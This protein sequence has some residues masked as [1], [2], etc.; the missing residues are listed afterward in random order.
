MTVVSVQNGER[1]DPSAAASASVDSVATSFLPTLKHAF[2]T[3]VSCDILDTIVQA[4]AQ[5][6]KLQ[7]HLQP[8]NEE[9]DPNDDN[10]QNNIKSS[11]VN[12]FWKQVRASDYVS[13]KNDWSDLRRTLLY[14]RTETRFYQEVLPRLQ[15]K[16]ASLVQHLTPTV[17]HA[18]YTLEPWI[19]EDERATALACPQIDKDTLPDPKS[20]GGCLIL[21]CMDATKYYQDSPLTIEECQHCL[22]AVA[23]LHAAA[24]QD[25]DLL[26]FAEERLSKAS[27]H[28]RMR[29]PKELAGI[30]RTWQDFVQAFELPLQDCGLWQVTSFQQMGQRMARLAEY[31]SDQVSPQ[32]TDR[33]A[34]LIHGDYKS[35]NVFL[36]QKQQCAVSNYDDLPTNDI[37]DDHAVLVDFAST[38]VGL[39]MSDL[40]MHIRHAVLPEHLQNG[41]EEALVR[42]YWEYLCTHI[43]GETQYPWEDAWRHYRLAVVDYFRFFLARMWKGATPATLAKK[44]DNKNVNLINR[45]IP[46]AIAFLQKV[47]EYLAEV[48]K[49]YEASH[50]NDGL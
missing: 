48:E 4:N 22:H 31:V 41:G 12:V 30:E 35:M 28:L 32:P 26:T 25:V 11:V 42:Y 34:T 15:A 27:F 46:A 21:E 17:Y 24:W 3:A 7:V 5:G 40:A 37:A 2:P 1:V 18:E 14:A 19:P 39:G 23:R 29:N 9:D 50:G 10:D 49:E 47:H 8:S 33:Y 45:N 6:F 36:P 44:R 20:K 16:H 13:V 43:S 38:G